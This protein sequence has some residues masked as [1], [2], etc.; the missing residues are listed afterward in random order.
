MI[1]V[2]M[3]S[4]P[5]F[6]EKVT[7]LEELINPQMISVG[8]DNLFVTEKTLVYI[9][10]LKDFKL[11]QKFGKEGEGPGE[12]K[13]YAVVFPLKDELLVNSQGRVSYFSKQGKYIKEIKSQVGFIGG[14][15]FA[16]VG[17]NFGGQGFTV[18]NQKFYQTFNLFDSKLAKIKEVYRY[19]IVRS[20]EKIDPLTVRLYRFA[21]KSYKDRFYA[22]NDADGIIKAFDAEGKEIMTVNYQFADLEVTKAHIKEMLEHYKINPD[23]KGVYERVKDR[24]EF[25]KYYPKFY[26]FF[27]GDNLYVL[28]YN[29]RDNKTEFIIF[30]KKGKFVKKTMVPFYQ[31]NMHVTYP[32]NVYG[33][34][35]YQVVENEDDES[36]EL[37]VNTIK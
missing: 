29:R 30:D 22:A 11:V 2:L 37:H 20:R 12:F 10:S 21:C 5:V 13:R 36:W 8:K 1:A 17:K 24:I 26:D 15:A 14:G 31:T 27:P 28:T 16:P 7:E 6:G 33:N 19:Q 4:T 32:Y 3:V 18:E 35:L 25:P 9:Y 23:T 34:K